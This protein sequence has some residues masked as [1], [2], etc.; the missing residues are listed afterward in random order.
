[1][2]LHLAGLGACLV[3]ESWRSENR[4][5]RSY[6]EVVNARNPLV[7]QSWRTNLR[8]STGFDWRK[9]LRTSRSHRKKTKWGYARE[10]RFCQGTCSGLSRPN[11][12]GWTDWIVGVIAWGYIAEERL[13]ARNGK[14]NA[15]GP[16]SVQAEDRGSPRHIWAKD[17]PFRQKI[18]STQ[19]LWVDGNRREPLKRRDLFTASNQHRS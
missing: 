17:H 13:V 7:R 1:M 11:R 6:S 5:S 14:I 4:L 2:Q 3:F 9:Y 8:K 15:N 12:V 19:Q 10:Y 16:K 18:T